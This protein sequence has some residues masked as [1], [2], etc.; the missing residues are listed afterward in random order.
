M[1]PIPHIDDK[2]DVL[3][4]SCWFSTLDLATGYWLVE[5]FDKDKEKTAFSTPFGLY[6]FK[7]NAFWAV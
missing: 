2:L 7:G 4:G 5:V 3:A 1:H 6:H